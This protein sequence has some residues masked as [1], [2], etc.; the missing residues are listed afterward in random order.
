[1]IHLGLGLTYKYL[2]KLKGLLGTNTRLLRKSVYYDSKKFY[3][4]GSWN[5]HRSI[6]Q[7]PL[8]VIHRSAVFCQKYFDLGRSSSGNLPR[9][10]RLHQSGQVHGRQVEENCLYQ[11]HQKASGQVNQGI[12]SEWEGSVQ[13]TSLYSLV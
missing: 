2:T 1:V 9:P 3:R 11:R 6:F 13:L 12:L 5:D 8:H 4:I 10:L 7:L